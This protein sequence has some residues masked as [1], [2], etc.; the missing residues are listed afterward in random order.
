MMCL[1]NGICLIRCCWKEKKME[2]RSYWVIASVEPLIVLFRDGTVRITTQPYK[3][4]DW[5][6]PLIHITNTKQQKKA[7]PHYYKTEQLRKWTVHQLADYLLKEKKI[8]GDPE[9]WLNNLREMLI[10]RIGVMVLAVHPQL[11]KQKTKT[12]WDGRFELFGMDVILDENLH[13]WLTELQDGP[14]LSMDPGVKQTV[15][16]NLIKDL[17]NVELE[18]DQTL[19]ASK[20]L[21]KVKSLGGWIQIDLEKYRGLLPTDLQK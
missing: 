18:I 9:V 21:T 11:I 6:N 13:P 3:H 7:D 5:E 8:S 15:V 20:P 12:G 17:M 14:S 16:P 10:E 4:G 19:R 1:Y 2:I